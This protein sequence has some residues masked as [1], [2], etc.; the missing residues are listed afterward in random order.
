MLSQSFMRRLRT[1]LVSAHS[2]VDEG[3]YLLITPSSP[4]A[5]MRHGIL[6]SIKVLQEGDDLNISI[7]ITAPSWHWECVSRPSCV[8]RLKPQEAQ[9]SFLPWA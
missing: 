2:R 1:A 8:Q 6:T 9:D 5:F 7:I 3:N 4:N